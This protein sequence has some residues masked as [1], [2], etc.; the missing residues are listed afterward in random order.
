VK[1]IADSAQTPKTRYKL[2]ATAAV[3]FIAVSHLGI[4]NMI[5][6]ANNLVT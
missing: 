2:A 3:I 4:T 6:Y 5:R 1:R